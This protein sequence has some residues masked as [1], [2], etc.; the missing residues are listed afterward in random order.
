MLLDRWGGNA[1]KPC[2]WGRRMMQGVGETLRPR[3]SDRRGRTSRWR[4]I[5]GP[6][7]G[8]RLRRPMGSVSNMETRAVFDLQSASSPLP[9]L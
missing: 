2:C 9:I 4:R 5:P 8:S 7:T 6:V 3:E 1:E